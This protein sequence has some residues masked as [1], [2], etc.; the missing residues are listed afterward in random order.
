MKSLIASARIID[1]SNIT[2]DEAADLPD[3]MPRLD[4]VSTAIDPADPKHF[5]VASY[6]TGLYEYHNDAYYAH[7]SFYNSPNGLEKAAADANGYYYTRVDGPAFDTDGNLWMLNAGNYAN[8][9][10]ILARDG[11]WRSFN[12]IYNGVRKVFETPGQILVDRN[13]PNH[14]WLPSLRTSTSAGA[15]VGIGLIDDNGTPLDHS[16]DRMA[17]HSSFVDQF[18]STVTPDIIYCIAQDNEGAVWV[19]TNAGVFSIPSNHNFFQSNA[20]LRYKINRNDGSGLADFLLSSESIRASAHDGGNRHWFGTAGNGVFLIQYRDVDDVATIYHFT[21]ANSPLPSD[22]VLSI[23][24]LPESGEVFFGTESGLASFRSDAS[25]P[26]DNFSTAYVYPNPVR[27]DYG[28]NITFAGLMEAT[29]VKVVD[30]AGNLV[31]STRSNGGTAV[32][33][34]RDANGRK[35]APGVYRAFCN[36][37]EGQHTVLKVLIIH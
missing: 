32:W 2:T 7:H 31:F 37:P 22:N 26:H 3:W 19:G 5:F 28:G 24:I 23:A 4:F 33:N 29:Y 21:T 8:N 14:K 18:G 1:E 35:V 10:C 36:T 13:R 25:A 11:S 27:P 34:G 6:G 9:I 15:P 20:C 17:F 30:E 12:L 16:D